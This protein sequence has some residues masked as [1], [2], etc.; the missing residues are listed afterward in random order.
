MR[1]LGNKQ[2]IVQTIFNIMRKYKVQGNSI[3]DFFAGSTSVSKFFKQLNYQVTTADWM[4]YSY[5]LQKAYIENNSEP[6]F[7]KIGC[8]CLN[9][10]ICE[11]NILPGKVGYIYLNYTKEG[12]NKL[13][14]PRAFFSEDNAKKIDAIRIQ[15]QEWRD[16]NLLTDMEY[17][18]LIACLVESIEYYANIK[19]DYSDFNKFWVPRALRPFVLTSIQFLNNG[20]ENHSYY[21][22]SMSLLNRVSADILYLDPPFTTYQY[23]QSYHLLETIAKY[24]CP[25][26]MGDIGFRRNDQHFSAFCTEEGAKEQL[27][28]IVRRAQCN[29]IV[30]SYNSLGV[31]SKDTILEILYRYGKVAV[32]RFEH[33][34]L[35]SEMRGMP[36]QQKVTEY[37]F[38]LNK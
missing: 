14:R 28:E 3:F 33:T 36:P 5:V 21:A 19:E 2:A 38:I 29:Y 23:N 22:D 25:P 32:E 9:D 27:D 31:L 34:S 17:S 1:Y 4:Y 26:L 6:T 7:N 16:H 15:I 37:V 20:L 8:T 10:A 18:I 24:D 12:T 30:M 11:L 35:T 13:D